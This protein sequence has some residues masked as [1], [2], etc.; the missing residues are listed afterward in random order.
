MSELANYQQWVTQATEEP[1]HYWRNAAEAISWDR[2]ADTILDD[3]DKP[4]YRWFAGAELNTCFNAVDRHVIDGYGEQD[5]IIYDSPVTGTKQKI[6]YLQL[7]QQVASLAGAMASAGVTKGDRVV[8]Y[9]PMIPQTLVAM[10]ACARLGAIHSVVFGGF[11]APELATRIDDAKPKL[12]LSASCGIEPNRLIPYKP[13]L[14]EAIELST[15]KPDHTIIYQR[16]QLEAE[17][18]VERDLDWLTACEQAQPHDCVSVKATDPLYILYTSGTTGQ[19]KGVVRD[20][21]GHAVAL[22][23]SMKHIYN[24][25]PGDVFWAASD[26]GWVV[27]HSYICYG[28]LINRCTTIVFEGKPIG[29]PDAGT[30]WRII[31]EYQVKSFFTAPT[32]FRAIRGCDPDG[33]FIK[34]YDISCLS[35]LYL[36][37][38]RCDPATLTWAQEQLQIPVVDHWWQTETGWPM[39]ANLIG[40]CPVPIKA[41][42]PARAVPGFNIEIVDSAGEPVVKGESGMIV[43]KLPLPPGTLPTL[44]QNNQRYYDAYLSQVEGYYLTGDA[45][46]IDSDDYLWVMNRIDDVINVAGHRLS[47]GRIEEVLS[48]H[49]SIAEAAVIGVNDELKGELPLGLVVLSSDNELSQ[50][51]VSKELIALVR[52]HIGAVAAF[53][54]VV[55]VDKLPKTRSGKILRATMKKIANGDTYKVPATIEDET[56][57][58]QIADVLATA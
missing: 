43:V 3:A 8:I 7:Q 42:S 52:E 36:A 44:W 1:E 33:D 46:Y 41:G 49:A 31:S 21:G 47:T 22:A 40:A 14:D 28:P 53:K 56:V 25:N 15:H 27:G 37:G 13:L 5:A 29:T 50:D 19:P 16:Q 6:T 39:A 57:L 38:E 30:F 32:A 20:N 18:Q 4:F 11:A 24:V 9:M 12:V 10:L 48:E 26:V 17:L 2:Q 58:A 45:G 51:E 34:Q 54:H 55:V 23:W 35:A